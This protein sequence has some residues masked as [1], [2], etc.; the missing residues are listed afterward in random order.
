MQIVT[1]MTHNKA[2]TR[3]RRSNYVYILRAFPT[4]RH[5]CKFCDVVQSARHLRL[6]QHLNLTT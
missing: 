2:R 4:V 5:L 6:R 3:I 1:V